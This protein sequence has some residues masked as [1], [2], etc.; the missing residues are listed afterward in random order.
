MASWSYPFPFAARVDTPA[1]SEDATVDL[2]VGHQLGDQGRIFA[3]G[4]FFTE[5]RH[6]GTPLQTNDTRSGEGAFGL[7]RQFGSEDSLSLR[8]YG[9][10]QGYNQA[11]SAVASDRDSESLTDLQHVPEQV[12]GG[13]AQWTHFL[14]KSQTL[15]AGADLME[16]M[17]ASDEQLYSSGTHTRNNAAGGRQRILGLFGEDILRFRQKW[18]IILA[19]R[20]DD[21]SN[22]NA[23][24]ICTPVS[25]SCSS[26][27]SAQY[28]ARS[29]MAFDPR[30]SVLRSLNSHVSLT[31][32]IYRAFRAPTLNE[33]Y[34]TFR[35]GN[36]L[37]YNNP[38]L[39]AERLTGAEAGVNVTGW[40]RKLEL[41]RNF[42]LERHR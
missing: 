20:F 41:A 10:V 33:L 17:G 38:S 25:G 2:N 4:N 30:L 8:A 39:N 37:T 18:T 24:S 13:G 11:F 1:N 14:G 32:S 15:I 35:V 9:L 12:G 28:P 42:F 29:D 16:V 31:G 21:W 22:F 40:E 7:D 23:S 27:P 6:N 36:I 19:G 34:R 5:F 26:S 3:R